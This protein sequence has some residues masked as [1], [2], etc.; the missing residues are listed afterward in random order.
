M[1]G[2]GFVLRPFGPADVPLLARWRRDPA[3]VAW[4]GADAPTDEE[5]L[6]AKYVG[7][8]ARAHITHAV[9][10]HLGEP[11]GFVQWYACQPPYLAAAGLPADD[12]AWA[13]D[14]HLAPELIGGGLG[15]R[16]VRLVAAH[17]TA[18]GVPRVLIDPEA[19][20]ARAIRAYEKAGFVR[21]RDLPAY[22]TRDGVRRDHLLLEW[23]G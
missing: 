20:N 3:V 1:A 4:Y 10:E 2:D 13:I 14:L 18:G 12:G 8:P 6:A 23:R 9:A 21:V 11:A 15:S 22:S 17:L 5:S 19:A 16:L 7:N